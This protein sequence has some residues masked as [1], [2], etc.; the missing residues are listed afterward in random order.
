MATFLS[1]HSFTIKYKSTIVKVPKITSTILNENSL[2][3]QIIKETDV[4]GAFLNQNTKN[5][6]K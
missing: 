4:V 3:P 1:Y 5:Q 2:I 6:K